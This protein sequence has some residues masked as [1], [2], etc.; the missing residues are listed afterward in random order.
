[1]Q[2]GPSAA[3]SVTQ[4]KGS[5]SAVAW[6]EVRT[7]RPLP[8]AQPP[9]PSALAALPVGGETTAAGLLTG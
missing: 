6:L 1:M 5:A 9:S 7:A 8:W 3:A 4:G 2:F